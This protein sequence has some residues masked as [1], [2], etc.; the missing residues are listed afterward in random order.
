MGRGARGNHSLLTQLSAMPHIYV[1][2]L[3]STQHGQDCTARVK[4]NH[5]AVGLEGA[6]RDHR[7]QARQGWLPFREPLQPL[8]HLSM[9]GKVH[10]TSREGFLGVFLTRRHCVR[11]RCCLWSCRA[12]GLE[13]RGTGSSYFT[14]LHQKKK[15]MKCVIFYVISALQPESHF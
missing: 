3:S 6:S 12:A 10:R 7:V 8:G 4:Q 5:R 14:S 11:A 9:V 2:N 15:L 1:L 13:G